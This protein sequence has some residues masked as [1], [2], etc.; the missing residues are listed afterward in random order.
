MKKKLIVLCGLAALGTLVAGVAC[1]GSSSYTFDYE[2]LPSVEQVGIVLDDGASIDGE[3]DAFYGENSV[4]FTEVLSGITVE[5][6]AHLGEKGLYL[7]SEADDQNIYHSY[8]RS[9]WENDMI[10]YY[11]DPRPDY[12]FTTAA[13][14]S[15]MLRTDCLNL[16][17]NALGGM[18]TWIGR[19]TLEYPWVE[20]YFRAVT[21][22][23]VRGEIN[24][25]G[26]AAGYSTEAF[27]PWSELGLT[28]KP[29]A[30]GVMPAFNNVN[31]REDTSRTWFSVKGMNHALLTSYA[32]VEENGFV[33][34]G[35]DEMPH[36]PL[37]AME[38][39]AFY[40]GAALTLTE[41]TAEQTGGEERASIR[42]R[43]GEDGL[44]FHAIVKDKV[45][46]DS[47]DGLWDNDGIELAIDTKVAGG[48]EIYRDGIVRVGIDIDGGLGI[49]VTRTGYSDFISRRLPAFAVCNRAPYRDES[50][51]GYQYQYIY[52]GMVPYSTLGLSSPPERLS[53]AWAVKSVNET[54]YLLDRR[55][56]NGAPEGSDW[57]W[58][59]RHY[60][61]NPNEFYLVT[62]DGATG[63]GL[64]P[65][66]E[67]PAWTAW[68]D[69]AIRSD[70]PTRYDYRGKAA[71]NGLY[72]NMVQYTDAYTVGGE[73]GDWMR[74]THIELEIWH[75]D[76]G[77]G[78]QNK[79]AGRDA[80]E[81]GTY[82]AFF[83]DGSYYCNNNTGIGQI[84]FAVSV[85]DLGTGAMYRYRISYEIY[86]GF[87][88]NIDAPQDGA[89]GFVQFMSFLPGGGEEGYENCSTVTKDGT[90][91]L[92]TDACKSCELR[93]EGV[94]R[95]DR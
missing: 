56:G 82:F 5:S 81:S 80:F 13:L 10:E 21:A 76:F 31:N 51:F 8:E 60:P 73:S 67:F 17:V 70:A 36:K 38:D 11:V 14:N 65:A 90:R 64:R 94:V 91:T 44:Y 46:T 18:Q 34:D 23:K 57:L 47:D 71:D 41:V 16:R 55:D 84:E 28:S 83:T 88:N 69:C 61:R 86:I 37:Q 29:A 2:H 59:D 62:A 48:D 19:S 89:Y 25:R 75:D 32:R 68:E 95:K 7:Y 33:N 27:I 58:A 6:W 26:G 15:A 45:L 87:D 72:L 49:S 30:V 85:E 74:S 4:S 40:C 92:Q 50:A 52:E 3:K 93:S 22:A 43:L 20:G 9:F 63:G 24:V 66:F 1:G 39:D 78:A 79:A 42:A 35:F 53:F 77:Y 54:A 12:S